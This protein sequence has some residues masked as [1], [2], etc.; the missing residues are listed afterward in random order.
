MAS[1]GP[2]SELEKGDFPKK[3]FYKTTVQ[4][5]WV[6]QEMKGFLY[7]NK[8]KEDNSL[9]IM[10]PI[11]TH[12]GC[13]AGNAEASMKEN[14]GVEFYCPCHGGKY[15]EQGINVGGP[16]PRSLDVFE[17]FIED[18]NVCIA[19]LSPMVREKRKK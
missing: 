11:C 2:L 16:P 14:E 6:E 8:N 7:I 18:K 10:S 12:L 9:L 15:D 1:L 19:I 4:D 3:V 17:S 13:A 5:A